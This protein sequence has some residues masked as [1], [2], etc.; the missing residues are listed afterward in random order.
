M[1]K[2]AG[3]LPCQLRQKASVELIEQQSSA[4]VNELCQK[5]NVTYT[6]IRSDLEY[7]ERVGLLKRT[8]GGA[9]QCAEKRA[10]EDPSVYLRELRHREEKD[11]IAREAVKYI[12][13]GDV[14]GT[15]AEPTRSFVLEGPNVFFK[16]TYKGK[17]VNPVKYLRS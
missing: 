9:T 1:P 16:M 7:L 5:F 15:V 4:T 14:I 12:Q 6:T 11:A 13:E 17:A 8:Y 2:K 3:S 10:P